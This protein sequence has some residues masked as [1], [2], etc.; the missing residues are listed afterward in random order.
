MT[1]CQCG[2]FVGD[3]WQEQSVLIYPPVAGKS[4]KNGKNSANNYTLE[5]YWLAASEY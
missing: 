5:A 4:N 1:P 2:T 3:I